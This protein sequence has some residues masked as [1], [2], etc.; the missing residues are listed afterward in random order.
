[1]PN[2]FLGENFLLDSFFFSKDLLYFPYVR[3]LRFA[4]ESYAYRS[5]DMT[6]KDRAVF[7]A[8]VGRGGVYRTAD[9]GTAHRLHCRGA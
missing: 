7:L 5:T 2:S 8:P 6:R 4:G 1:M 9:K 3:R